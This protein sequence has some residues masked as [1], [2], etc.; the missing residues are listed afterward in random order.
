M[1]IF[2]AIYGIIVFDQVDFLSSSVLQVLM[3]LV[4][5]VYRDSFTDLDVP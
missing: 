5:K 1:R 4:L 3:L 2:I